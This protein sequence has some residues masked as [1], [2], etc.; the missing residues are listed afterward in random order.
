VQSKKDGQLVFETKPLPYKGREI[1]TKI[2]A[3][4]KSLRALSF[5]STLTRDGYRL[6]LLSKREP[7]GLPQLCVCYAV[8]FY[9]GSLTRYKPYDYDKITQGFSW[10]LGEF[11]DTQPPQFLTHLASFLGK[12]EVVMPYAVAVQSK[13]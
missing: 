13:S 6:Y 4:A 3:L 2:A 12:T 9:L 5:H 7:S 1:E 8:M 10:L 11:L